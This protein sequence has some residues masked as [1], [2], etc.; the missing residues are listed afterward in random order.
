M[1]ISRSLPI[2]ASVLALVSFPGIA[3]AKKKPADF[4]EFKGNYVGQPVTVTYVNSPFSATANVSVAV[5]KNGKSATITVSGLISS[6]S[7]QA[8]L[9]NTFT[10]TKNSI[11]IANVVYNL[12]AVPAASGSGKLN[13]AGTSFTYTAFIPGLAIP[14]TGTISVKPKGKKQKV[15]SVGLQ[16]SDG[17]TTYNFPFTAVGKASKK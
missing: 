15:I 4:S 3:E 12:E 6:G 9:T 16:I 7:D 17:S 14:I 11:T 13:R 2:L 1:K 5:P 8:P 10:L